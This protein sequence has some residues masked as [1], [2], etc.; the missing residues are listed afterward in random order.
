MNEANRQLQELDDEERRLWAALADEIRETRRRWGVAGFREAVDA[1]RAVRKSRAPRAEFEQLPDLAHMEKIREASR[2]GEHGSVMREIF[3]LDRIKERLTSEIAIGEARGV[4]EEELRE[5]RT[6]CEKRRRE[7]ERLFQRAKDIERAR[8]RARDEIK[9]RAAE[10]ARARI[11]GC[12]RGGK[13]STKE[14]KHIKERLRAAH[15]ANPELTA[16]QF[17]DTLP[18]SYGPDDDDDDVMIYRDGENAVETW[19]GRDGTRRER[20]ITIRTLRSYLTTIR[21]GG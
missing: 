4:R 14:A 10:A 7:L 8:R 5:V 1:V 6:E 11:D 16:R 12:R 20:A 21:V 2:D 15:V 9:R 18:A 17:L 19:I 13:S 3:R